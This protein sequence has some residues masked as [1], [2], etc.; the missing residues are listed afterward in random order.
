MK[1]KIAVFANGWSDEYLLT[2]LKGI[3]KC[4]TENDI[5][6]YF[7]VEYASANTRDEN[8]QGEINLLNLP[9]LDDFDGALLMGNTLTNAGELDILREKILKADIPAVCLEYKVDG[10]DCICT[11]NYSGMRELC[12]HLVNEH[13]VKTVVFVS[14]LADNEENQERLRAVRDVLREHKLSLSDDYIVPGEWSFYRVQFSLESWLKDHQ[15]PDAIVCANDTM[16]FGVITLMVRLGY[17]MPRDVI[18]TGFDNLNSSS[19]FVPALTTV[20]RKWDDR[21][22]E[23]FKHLI[24]LMDGKPKKG[25]RYFPSTVVCRESCGCSISEEE[26]REQLK[27]INQVYTVPID[28][29][30][31]DWHLTGLDEATTGKSSVEEIHDSL[32]EFF[33]EGSS[34][35]EGDTFCICVDE[36]F[37][38]SFSDETELKY[39]GYS[40]QM[41]V[42]YGKR[43]GKHLPYQKIKT[44]YIFPVFSSPDEP[45][46]IYLIAP[47]HSLSNCLG[48]GVFKNYENVLE[49]YFFYSWLR[50]L[51]SGL[52]R[53]RQNIIMDNMN[54]RLK[55]FS[56]MDELS[57]LLN[58][59]GYEKK[60]IPLLEGI[61][62]EKKTAMMMVVDINHMK[63][64]NDRYGH[65]SGDLAIRLV[66]KAIKE[67]IPED[68]CGIRYGGDEFVVIGEKLFVDDGAML[69]NRLCAAVE[70]A[71]KALMLPFKLTV[72]VGSVLVDPEK[73]VSLDEYFSMA[74]TAMYE[75]K[76]K[77]HQDATKKDGK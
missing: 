13:Q 56:L 27:T 62:D 14:G 34:R 11:D 46:N 54:N 21:S 20:N 43:D 29:T 73:N 49:T 48:Y 42:L 36:S 37:I 65:L 57:G 53:C 33:G 9:N 5:D 51:K 22:Y 38:N 30:L 64:I 40:E 15:L 8:V 63:M 60:G 35:Y 67:T 72:S 74:D 47:L 59:K 12:E 32:K 18:V 4:A 77:I 16:A 2:A 76:K 50:H 68:W 39:L 45:A 66:A 23:G 31:F 75:M 26:K 25:I 17:D 44:S 6:V 24:D 28:R 55:E 52:L 70:N 19:K 41:H 71:A 10:I 69:K 58:R 3:R 61:R 1:R 7:F